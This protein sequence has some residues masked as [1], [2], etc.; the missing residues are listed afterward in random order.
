MHPLRNLKRIHNEYSDPILD[1]VRKDNFA[2]C[3]VQVW[4]ILPNVSWNQF[5]QLLKKYYCENKILWF[6]LCHILQ[7]VATST[8]SD[9]TKFSEK[10]H[11]L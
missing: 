11:N 5:T 4:V 9:F 3:D 6:S 8:L 1:T 2:H 10:A 7:T